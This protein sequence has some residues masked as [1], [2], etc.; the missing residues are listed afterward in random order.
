MN[1]GSINIRMVGR[2]QLCAGRFLEAK[3]KFG[4]DAVKFS[5]ERPGRTLQERGEAGEYLVVESV[6][7]E[8]LICNVR[9]ESDG[10]E[11]EATPQFLVSLAHMVL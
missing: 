10:S 3:I 2:W 1:A 8:T 4:E 6:S 7:L 9:F 11:I 5:D